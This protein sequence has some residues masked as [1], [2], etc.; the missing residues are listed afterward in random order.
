MLT[1]YDAGD[2]EV[3]EQLTKSLNQSIKKFAKD[4]RDKYIMKLCD[5]HE[6]LHEFYQLRSNKGYGTKKHMEGIQKHGITQWHR[7]TFGICKNYE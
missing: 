1:A 7:R 6:N 2:T 5:D 4:I 3:I